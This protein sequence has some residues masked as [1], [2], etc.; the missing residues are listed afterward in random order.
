MKAI[1]WFCGGGALLATPAAAAQ[2]RDFLTSDEVDQIREAQ[3]PNARLMLY[4]KFAR[5]RISNGE[6]PAG[7][8]EGR[9]LDPGARRAGGL[10]EDHRCDRRRG[11]RGVEEEGRAEG[12]AGA[13]GAD[14]RGRAAGAETDPGLQ[15]KDIE[16]YEFVLRTAID[17]T[18]DSLDL[19]ETDTS[20]GPRTWRPGR[21]GR[22]RRSATR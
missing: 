9:A 21:S 7:E 5:Q 18:R 8:G 16:R 13:G 15:P 20:S 10:C 11:G 17:T 1:A 19:A 3:E 4:A 22:K 6:E 2:Q 12:R 14:G